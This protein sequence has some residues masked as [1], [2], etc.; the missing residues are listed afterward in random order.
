VSSGTLQFPFSPTLDSDVTVEVG[1]LELQSGA[2]VNGN[3]TIES[4]RLLA[5]GP[6]TIAGTLQQQA[7]GNLDVS[8]TVTVNGLFTWAGGTQ[9]GVGE[10]IANGGVLITGAN[11]KDLRERSLSLHAASSWTGSG[12]LTLRW[13]PTINVNAPF[14]IATDADIQLLQGANPMINISSSLTKSA[15]AGDTQIAAVI[16]NSGSIAVASGQLNFQRSYVQSDS[17]SLD[18]T[19]AGNA[20]FD[21]F[22]VAEAATLD[23]AL[24]INRVGGYEPALGETFEILTAASVT[25]TF[26][27]VTGTPIVAGRKFDVIYGANNVTLEVVLE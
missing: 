14:D 4:G 27:T 25:G 15:G 2:T 13:G 26:A 11:T 3:F 8:G 12:A 5:A 18:V 22:P 16:G 17:G 23:G 6:V 1:T 24:N 21:V 9:Q 20:D 7:L 10:T 19:I